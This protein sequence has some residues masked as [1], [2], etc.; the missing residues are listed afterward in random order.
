MQWRSTNN[1]LTKKLRET[2]VCVGF[3][4]KKIRIQGFQIG[5]NHFVIA[6]K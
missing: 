3:E 2:L 1:I 4:E 5:F 6:N